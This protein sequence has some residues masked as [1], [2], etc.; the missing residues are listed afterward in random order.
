MPTYENINVPP[1][2]CSCLWAPP[3]YGTVGDTERYEVAWCTKARHGARLI[4][5][6]TIT[7]A[8]V[9]HT[10]KYIQI[11][12]TLNQQNL[13]IPEGDSGGELDPSGADGKGNPIG[14]IVVGPGKDGKM[15]QFNRWTQFIGS[16]T[17]GYQ[18]TRLRMCK[19]M[20]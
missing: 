8:H 18:D 1:R 9:V 7:G 17:V 12:G 14:G 19:G 15:I 13:N 10:S 11:T 6:G 16:N 2:S 4:P 3:Q 20:R 5:A